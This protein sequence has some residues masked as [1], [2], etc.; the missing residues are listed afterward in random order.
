MWNGKS[1]VAISVV[2]CGLFLTLFGGDPYIC[3]ECL[4]AGDYLS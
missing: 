2:L 3:L 4:Q 1:A